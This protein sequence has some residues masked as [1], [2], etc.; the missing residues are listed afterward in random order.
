MQT[1]LKPC[2]RRFAEWPVDQIAVKNLV[3]ISA[4]VEQV[5]VR[6]VEQTTARNKLAHDIP[7]DPENSGPSDERACNGTVAQL[8][9][10]PLFF[11]TLI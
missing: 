4:E 5:L 1:R 7:P 8:N 2:W 9:A 11:I 3:T 6:V 10:Q